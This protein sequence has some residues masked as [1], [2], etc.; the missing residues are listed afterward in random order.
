MTLPSDIRIH[1]P[2]TAGE[3]LSVLARF[4][5]AAAPY[6]GGTELLPVLKLGLSSVRHLVDVRLI[7]ELSGLNTTPGAALRLGAA[8][9][10]RMVQRSPVV[11]DQWPELAQ[12]ERTVGNIR[13]QGSGS[14]GG[15]L[16][17][18]DPQ[19]DP[20]TFLTA[21]G[22]R[23]ACLSA[24]H[25]PRYL[26]VDE[27][28]LGPYTNGL[29]A[30]EELLGWIELPPRKP[31]T[32][33]AH[34]KV[35]FGERPEATCA[36]LLEFEDGRVTA[37]RVAIGS[38]TAAPVLTARSAELLAMT[39]AEV[40]RCAEPFAESIVSAL[41]DRLLHESRTG[42][43]LAVARRLVAG[44]VADAAASLVP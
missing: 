37:A 33:M 40:V 8:V 18:A 44:V 36:A 13:V 15:N 32:A 9:T 7:P 41:S 27:F 34:R 28:V 20:A 21:A 1:R 22:A 43:M 31:N 39:S 35:T 42:F 6:A 5:D 25:P 24:T 11:L 14:V 16:C 26:R 4:E 19:S 38:V 29:S 10:H 17:F 2:L 3:A 12:M 30:G 23:L